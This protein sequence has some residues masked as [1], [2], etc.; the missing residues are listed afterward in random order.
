MLNMV[1]A[2]TSYN[3]YISAQA[4]AR[5]YVY[6]DPNALF[7]ALPPGAIPAFPNVPAAGNSPAFAAAYATPFGSFFSLDGV[8]PNAAAH[9]LI[10]QALAPAINAAYTTV[11]PPIP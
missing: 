1:A 4:A 11:I 8:H 5:G 10:A 2:V 9:R 6:I 7:A 3:T